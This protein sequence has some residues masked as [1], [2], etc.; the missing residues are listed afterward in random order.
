MKVNL[1][2]SAGFCF[3]VKRAIDIALE[4][5]AREN[6]VYMLG[7]I[8]HNEDVVAS[9]KRAGIK[10]IKRL[11]DGLGRTL[12]IR[13]HGTCPKTI[14]QAMRRGYKIIDATCPMVKEIHRL[15]LAMEK[16]KRAVII[17]GD[18]LH[19]EVHGIAGQL[20]QKA[21]IIPGIKNIPLA[22]VKKIKKA[23]VLAQSTQ[24][25][26]KVLRIVHLLKFYIPDLLF[27]NTIC[28]PTRLK[29]QEIRCLPLENDV[30]V[31]IGSKNSANTKRLYQISKSL[32]KKSRWITGFHQLKPDWFKDA[33]SVGVTAGAST[34]AE[35]IKKAV[36][37]IN[38]IINPLKP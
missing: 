3:G 38:K 10:K 4:T 15:A 22:R 13:A 8:V 25:T 33:R 19:D 14:H 31:I 1:A 12:L 24:D 9:I 18:R 23:A 32:N 30:M 27:F 11:T 36:E 2:K 7:D 37:R 16:Q 5:A 26:Q 35:T 6:K 34:P 21:L 29:Q 20:R 17:I 28:R